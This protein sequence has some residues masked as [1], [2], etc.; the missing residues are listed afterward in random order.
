MARSQKRIFSY[1]T[2]KIWAEN[3]QIIMQVGLTM[4][5]CIVFGLLAR[6]MVLFEPQGS[7]TSTWIWGMILTVNKT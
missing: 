4:A 7:I 5:G 1:K 2:N 3:L 6:I